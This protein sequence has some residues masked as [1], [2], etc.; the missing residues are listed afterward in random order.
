M[1]SPIPWDYDS[2]YQWYRKTL[3]Y[4]E[5]SAHGENTQI[6]ANVY[7]SARPKKKDVGKVE[8]FLRP[9]IRYI[10]KA[11]TQDASLFPHGLFLLMEDEPKS[12]K[13][14]FAVFPTLVETTKVAN[15]FTWC[16]DKADIRNPCHFHSTFYNYTRVGMLNEWTEIHKPDHFPAKVALPREGTD[17]DII[18]QRIH[19]PY[20]HALLDVMRWPW[21]H[22]E[23]E[24]MAGGAKTRSRTSSH[25][26]ARPIS[27]PAFVEL[28]DTHK[29]LRLFAFGIRRGN[30][31]TW[32]VA[33]SRPGRRSP[34]RIEA[35]F[36]FDMAAN[37]TEA[38]F[39]QH[40]AELM[41]AGI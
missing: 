25:L 35:A 30:V 3:T 21:I 27:S 24:P 5:P 36:V 26:Q 4:C 13:W 8:P 20:K 16:F 12:K 1:S 15:H 11:P 18:R 19:V 38:A 14:V 34:N 37:A 32:S 9:N 2:F 39:Q 28:W 33:L 7:E 41:S 22:H 31:I 40:L 6:Y 10:G 23:R 17:T 29:L